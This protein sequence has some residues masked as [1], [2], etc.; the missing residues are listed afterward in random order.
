MEAISLDT[1]FIV[2]KRSIVAFLCMVAH[3]LA[4]WP[5]NKRQVLGLNNNAVHPVCLHALFII[6]WVS[7][8]CRAPDKLLTTLL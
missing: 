8:G 1:H 6:A 4:L 5:Q 3:C 2:N 7:Y